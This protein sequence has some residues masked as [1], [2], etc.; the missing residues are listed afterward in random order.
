MTVTSLNIDPALLSNTLNKDRKLKKALSG[1]ESMFVQQLLKSMRSAYLSEDSKSGLGMDTMMSISD[2][3]LADH[4]GEN[5]G[6]G[7]A[8]L[9]YQYFQKQYNSENMQNSLNA[10]TK[11][12]EIDNSN[13]AID[14]SIKENTHKLLND[15]NESGNYQ[16]KESNKIKFMTNPQMPNKSYEDIKFDNSSQIKTSPTQ[17]LKLNDKI[18]QAVADS[19]ARY[20]LPRDLIKAVMQAESGGNHLAISSKGA[21]GLMQ[22]IDSTATDMGVKNTFDPAQNIEGGAKYLRLLL[23]RFDGDLRLAL[24]GYNAGPGNVE[25]Y[26]GIPPFSETITYVDKVINIM[27][28]NNES[29]DSKLSVE[30]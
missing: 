12:L 11:P 18:D 26:G 15:L 14:I 10:E 16:I 27:N 25:K 28:S 5:D 2:Q 30:K 7:I 3:A 19:T 4:I 17:S 24:A 6:L 1:F 22:L 29:K 8:K 9:M 13:S 21:K 23:D 20:S